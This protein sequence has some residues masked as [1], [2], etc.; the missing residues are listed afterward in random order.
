MSKT[1]ITRIKNKVDNLSV[2]QNSVVNNVESSTR[3]LN[4]E[5]ALVRVPTGASQIN[6]VTGKTEP[7]IELLMK[8]G[9]GTSTFD[10]LPWLSA[11]AADVYDW[12]KASTVVVD[13][14]GSNLVFKNAGGAAVYSVSLDKFALKDTIS[15][16]DSRVTALEGA[17]GVDDGG[18]NSV[19]SRLEAVEG[20]IE[21]LTGADTVEGS[22]AKAE[23]D[24]RAYTDEREVAIEAAYKEYA[25]QAETDAIAAA[26]AKIDVERSRITA[27][28]AIENVTQAELNAYKETV[29]SAISTA[30]SSAVTDAKAYTDEREVEIKTYADTA[31]SD[32]VAAAKSYTDTEVKK[33]TDAASGVAANLT[34]H[35]SDTNPHRITAETVGLGNVENKSTA[36]IKSEFTGSVATGNDGFVTGGSVYTAIEGAKTVAASDAAAKVKALA[37]NQVKTNTDNIGKNASAIAAEVTR[38]TGV[39]EDLQEQ[40]T[41]NATAIGLLTNGVSPDEV[42]GVND[43]IQYVKNHGTEVTGIKAD[44]KTNADN[45]KALSDRMNTAEDDIDGLLADLEAANNGIDEVKDRLDT[46]EADYLKEE[47]KYDDTDLQN[48]VKAIE[49]DYLKAEDNYDDTALAGRVTTVEG[50][51]TNLKAKDTELEAAIGTKLATETFN[52]HVNG[53]HAPSA[54]QIAADIE[55]AVGDETSARETAIKGI[56]DK[57]GTV[58]AGKTVVDMIGDAQTA[59]NNAA[60]EAARAHSRLDIVGPKVDTLNDIVD[61]YTTKG[62]IKS[63][64]KAV[65]DKFAD[66]AEASK[67]YTKDDADGKFALI[68]TVSTNTTNI[69]NNSAAIEDIQ[70]SVDTIEGSYA[71]C[72]GDKL[73]IGE[74]EIIFDCGGAPQA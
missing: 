44:I 28:E 64:I 74:E 42:D 40:I 14:A 2:W 67:V 7:V 52:G 25:D 39:E 58:A 27:L 69:S 70:E 8:V 57:I 24:A 12:A 22:V 45:I 1:I 50:E 13:D 71:K 10:Q 61:G 6:P 41:A 65:D 72:V 48:R 68:S 11:K 26:E 43:L 9:D 29:I 62:S 17:L 18:Q 59:G 63:A 33:A 20:A 31:E 23:K 34:A 5:I 36:T 19:S 21:T 37:D 38:A 3:L 47:D 60:S 4:G 73:Y 15:A 49:N 53:D 66:Y 16:L 51:I 56:N 46:I 35:T 54:T 32:A 55:T 30:K